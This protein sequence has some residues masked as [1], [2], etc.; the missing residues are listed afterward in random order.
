MNEPQ[1]LLRPTTIIVSSA[2]QRFLHNLKINTAGFLAVSALVITYYTIP[3]L[4]QTEVRYSGD[5][6]TK[7]AVISRN[8]RGL[9]LLDRRGQPFFTFDQ[10]KQRTYITLSSVPQFVQAAAISSE[11]QDFYYHPG[12][13]LKAIARS[14]SQDV[15]QRRLAYGGST[16]T[17][18]LIKNTILSSDKSLT[19]KAQEIVLAYD[20]EQ[21]YS[22]KD[23]LEMYL[24][25]VYFGEGAFG[26]EEA[27]KTYF[28]KSAKELDLAQSAL[29][30]GLLPAP[31][32]LSPLNGDF[33]QAKI[34]QQIVLQKMLDNNYITRAEKSQ[35]EEEKLVFVPPKKDLNSQ[36]FHFA[37]LVRDELTKMYG[38][39]YLVYSGL[40]VKTTVDLE[41]QD[42]AQRVVSA[43]VARLAPNRV[44][45]GAA[46]VI[47]P[48][49]G[50][51][52]A[53]VGSYNWYDEGFGKVDVAVSPRQPGSAFKP[54]YYSQAFEEGLITPA[55]ILKDRPT[56]YPV[57]PKPY[58]PKNYDGR[59]RGLVTARRALANSLNVPSVQVLNKVGITQAV[60]M[61]QRLGLSTLK[62][63]SEYGLSLAL[64]AAEVKL[65]DL[66]GAYA[67][68]ANRGQ[69]NKVT[70]ILEIRD[71]NDTVIYSYEPQP[72]RV[73]SPQTAFL[74]S[75]ILSD[76][77]T[78]AEVFGNILDIS[79]PA[80]VKTGTTEDYKDAWAIGYTPSLA[81]G[82]WVGNN[83]GTPMDNIAGSL[84]A[85]PIWQALMK[86]FLAGTAM[87][88]FEPPGG[89][90]TLT[91][92]S[93]N[94]LVA[95]E[96]AS[97]AVKE[98]FIEGTEPRGICQP[99]QPPSPAKPSPT[100]AP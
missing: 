26:I 52:K 36:A 63:P 60:E 65:L 74:I 5:L 16:I 96:A 31:S 19:R 69:Y 64:G 9:V 44:S 89:V 100:P 45:N 70:T 15:E 73:L 25:A 67:V 8:D 54:I 58:S 94:G 79:R 90:K 98:Y 49:T 84:G 86:K 66:T 95:K 32:Q 93:Y 91:I 24:N 27:A 14:L 1:I 57:K 42:F 39:D 22:K 72:E 71:K 2:G 76:S 20:V 33:T 7:Q 48:K 34:R 38:E 75:S 92:C 21:R 51:V 83:D 78:R 97:S 28:D 59:F 40:K 43:Q 3:P 87:E 41:W 11:D 82:A 85:A 12:F 35:A 68:F 17:Q 37:F 53:L 62:D 6:S 80:A 55:T 88:S 56:S 47:D 77:K 81:V 30:I 29:L 10:P 23:I 13:S 4:Y 61:G 18:Q 99:R 46:V 50:Q